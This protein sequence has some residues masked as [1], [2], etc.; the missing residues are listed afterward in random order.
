MLLDD[1]KKLW[2]ELIWIKDES[3]RHKTLNAWAYA[4]KNSVFTADDLERIPFTIEIENCNISFIHF[5]RTSLRISTEIANRLKDSLG[6]LLK[7]NM[8]YIIAGAILFNVGKLAEFDLV[9]GKLSISNKGKLLKQNFS[10][11]SIAERFD[12]PIEVLHI[13][14]NQYSVDSTSMKSAELTIINHAYSLSYE[15]LTNSHI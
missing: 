13:I 1:V 4:I 3:L 10:G 11:V 12:L 14:A 2:P 9:N 5:C 7:I 6:E 8:D 15:I